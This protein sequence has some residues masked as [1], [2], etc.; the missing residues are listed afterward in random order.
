MD[1]VVAAGLVADRPRG[2]GIAGRGAQRVVRALA[3]GQAD[4]VDRRQ[5]ED[6]EAEL[7]Q[8][9]QLLLDA[10]QPAPRAREQLIPGAEP[11]PQ[12]VD[13]ERAAA[14]RPRSALAA[15]ASAGRRRAAPRRARR[16]ARPTRSATSSATSPARARSASDPRRRRPPRRPA[17]QQH[18]LGE[19]TGEVVLAGGDL[20]LELVR[21]VPNAS[22]N[23][24]IVYSQRP[25]RSTVNSPRQRTPPRWAS[26]RGSSLSCQSPLARAAVARRATRIRS[27]PSRNASTSTRTVSPTQRLAG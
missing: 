11:R 27:W 25:I 23:A 6:V 13:L 5:V 19:L 14:G 22:V 12:P 10:L 26:S 9:R 7:G 17:E 20:A 21:Q 1:G 15:L 16:R 3:V 2:A 24:W 4:R 18:P 8:R